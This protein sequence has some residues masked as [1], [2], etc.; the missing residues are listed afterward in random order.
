MLKFLT[1]GHAV[2]PESVEQEIRDQQY[3]HPDLRQI[4]DAEWIV[5]DRSE[6]LEFLAAFARYEEHLV[7]GGR[8]RGECGVLALGRTHEYRIVID[9]NVP[10]VL[11][12]RE[13]LECTGT[14]GLLCEAIRKEQLT[15]PMVESLADDLI[16]GDYRLP[17]GPGGFKCWAEQQ[18]LLG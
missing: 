12:K 6:D 14:L 1:A 17:F 18:G 7:A 8:N 4:L 16:M 2:I 9:D 3:Q 10:R 5:V 15:V 13:K 11:A